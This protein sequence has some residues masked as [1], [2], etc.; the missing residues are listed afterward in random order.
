M[1]TES[2]KTPHN[3]KPAEPKD[4]FGEKMKEE[5]LSKD[6]PKPSVNKEKKVGVKQNKKN[7][8][9]IYK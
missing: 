6:I 9:P 1:K 4:L 2:N 7:N 8:P 5:K 3:F